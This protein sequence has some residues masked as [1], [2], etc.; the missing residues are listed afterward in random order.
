[1]PAAMRRDSSAIWGASSVECAR[2]ARAAARAYGPPEPIPTRPSSGSITSPVPDTMKLASASATARSASSRR[3]TRSMRHS[4]A[5]STAARG[6]L[7]RC[8][9]SF[10]SK[11]AKSVKASAAAPAKPARTRSW[12]ILRT[13]RAPA[14]MMV[15]PNVTCPSPATATRPRCRTHTTVVAWIDGVVGDVITGSGRPR[16]GRVV[17]AHQV[18]R[19]HVGVALGGGETAVAQQLL[20]ETEIRTRPQHVGGEAVAEGVGRDPLG[21]AGA[22]RAGA[23]DAQRAPRGEPAA[24]RV[25]EERPAPPA[26]PGQVG[27]EGLERRLPDR[28]DALLA[29]LAEN[30]HGAPALVEIVDVEAAALGHPQPARVEQLEQRAIARPAHRRLRLGAQE[31]GGLVHRQERREA[32]SQARSAHLARRIH[33]EGAAAREEAKAAPDRGQLARDRGLGELA[34]VQPRQV[35]PDRARIRLL[36]ARDLLSGEETGELGQ[37][38]GIAPEGVRRRAALD[39]LVFEKGSDRRVHRG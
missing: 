3:S 39:A 37:V 12:C 14:F 9:S 26:A 36:P 17:H 25:E 1:M 23:H 2:S 4:L 13:L 24:P 20:D 33:L 21:D 16:M 8:S 10:A 28:N 15:W 6:K 7:P 22:P 38:C 11:R 30:A 35:G 18:L 31:L 29:A 34:L 5:S 32:P 19:A 27:R